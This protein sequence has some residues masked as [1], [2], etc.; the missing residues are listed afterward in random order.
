MYATT[1]TKL[2]IIT[3][4]NTDLPHPGIPRQRPTPEQ[5]PFVVMQPP[6]GIDKLIDTHILKGAIRE[7]AIPLILNLC[8]FARRLVVENV[9]LAVDGLLF[10]NAFYDVAGT[11]VQPYWVTAGSDFVM[12]ALDFRESGLE[13]IPLRFILLAAYSFGDRVLEDTFV[14]PQ[15]KLF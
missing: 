15:L 7:L 12:Q 4:G 6:P 9:D 14:V 5:P 8:D 13:A 3:G 11:Q 1:P 10:A 2:H